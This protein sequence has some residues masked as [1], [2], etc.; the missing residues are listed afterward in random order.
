MIPGVSYSENPEAVDMQ[1]MPYAVEY[2]Y[3]GGC[4]R[5]LLATIF[6]DG[7]NIRFQLHCH[8]GDE[9][10][11]ELRGKDIRSL[12]THLIS[13]PLT[14][15]NL[16]SKALPYYFEPIQQNSLEHFQAIPLSSGSFCFSQIHECDTIP[17]EQTVIA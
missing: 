10:C 14:R 2:Y 15:N 8:Q 4:R 1:K 17:K 6:Y 9:V 11:K 16:R 13:L 12:V 7:R 5:R 3:R